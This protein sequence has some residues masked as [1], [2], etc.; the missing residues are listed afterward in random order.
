MLLVVFVS[1]LYVQILYYND[2]KL[3]AAQSFSFANLSYILER[4]PLI[5][6]YFVRNMGRESDIVAPFILLSF[7]MYRAKRYQILL[8]IILPI[9]L[10]YA[11][12]ILVYL[13]TEANLDWHLATSFERLFHQISYAY[14]FGGALFS[15]MYFSEI[16]KLRESRA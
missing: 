6:E 15:F 12:M 11:F 7:L 16:N 10:Y 8:A 5:M 1:S 9:V 4:F 2:I 13:L 3:V 14:I